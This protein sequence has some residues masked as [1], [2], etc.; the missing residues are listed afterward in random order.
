[1]AERLVIDHRKFIEYALNPNHPT[2]GDKARVFARALGYTKDNYHALVQQIETT[3]LTSEA[4][5][6]LTDIHGTHYWVDLS[7]LG[8]Q[9]QRAEIRTSWLIAPGQTIAHLTSVYVRKK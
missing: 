4:R 7:V 1:M 5:V 9:A 3:A 8:A 2:G 6:S